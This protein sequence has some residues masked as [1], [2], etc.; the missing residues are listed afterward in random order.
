MTVAKVSKGKYRVVISNI[1]AASLHKKFNVVVTTDSGD[2]T[3]KVSALHYVKA[4]LSSTNPEATDYEK[5][6]MGALYYY[7]EAAKAYAAAQANA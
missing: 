3:V 6:A 7:A 1:D 5:Q 4:A 2:T